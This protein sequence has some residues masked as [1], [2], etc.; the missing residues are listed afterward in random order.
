MVKPPN[1]A[2]RKDACSPAGTRVTRRAEGPAIVTL[3]AGRETEVVF[4]W[5]NESVRVDASFLRVR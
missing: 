2:G 4:G 5:Q 3:T 1:E